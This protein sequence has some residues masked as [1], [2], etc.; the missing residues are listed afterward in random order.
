[1]L[2]SYQRTTSTQNPFT[3]FLL[4]K[5]QRIQGL[6]FSSGCLTTSLKRTDTLSLASYGVNPAAKFF[7]TFF[8]R[9]FWLPPYHPCG[10]VG[11]LPP[12]G[13]ASPVRQADAQ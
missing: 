6:V 5:D 4:A 2:F 10:T 8:R 7:S 12:D 11:S 13:R 1:M 9:C 3:P